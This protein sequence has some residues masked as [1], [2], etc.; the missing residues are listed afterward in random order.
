LRLR[1]WLDSGI[2][3]SAESASSARPFSVVPV[4]EVHSDR[5]S[6]REAVASLQDLARSQEQNHFLV[7]CNGTLLWNGASRFLI[8]LPSA[9]HSVRGHMQPQWRACFIRC[10]GTTI[11]IISCIPNRY[12]TQ[13]YPVAKSHWQASLHLKPAALAITMHPLSF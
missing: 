12:G 9:D 1:L 8:C 11:P 13:W 10:L 6:I 7:I 4:K 2:A 5:P 3:D